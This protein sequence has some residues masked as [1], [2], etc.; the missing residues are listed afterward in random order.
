MPN[1]T[2]TLNLYKP[3]GSDR[4]G[5]WA[6]TYDTSNWDFLDHVALLETP[7]ADAQSSATPRDNTFSGSI[8]AT[9][10]TTSGS[11]GVVTAHSFVGDGTQVTNVNA[12]TVNSL[13]VNTAVPSGAVFTDTKNTTGSEET[14][15]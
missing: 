6:L 10:F 4:I 1:R 5:D 7:P 9:N 8:T 13:T 15:G 12:A 14:T 2:T 11:S 3:V